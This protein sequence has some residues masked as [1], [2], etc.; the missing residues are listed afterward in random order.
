MEDA[1]GDGGEDG[2]GG[3]GTSIASCD[4]YSLSCTE[5][6]DRDDLLLEFDLASRGFDLP[7]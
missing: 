6:T 5:I 3:V 2:A 4:L 1:E 7:D